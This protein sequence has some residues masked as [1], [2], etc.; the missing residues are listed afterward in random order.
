[1]GL[2]TGIWASIEALNKG[3]GGGG[4]NPPD[5][6]NFPVWNYRSS[7]PPE[8]LLKKDMLAALGNVNVDLIRAITVPISDILE[9]AVTKCKE[10]KRKLNEI[11]SES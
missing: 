2:E 7:A 9:D 10:I 11:H 5:R 6:K 8:P 4:R 3:L 1:M